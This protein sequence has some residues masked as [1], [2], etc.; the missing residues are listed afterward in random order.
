MKF[1]LNRSG[2]KE[3][4]K[5]A[6]MQSVLREYTSTVERN[7]GSGYSS[8][9]KVGRNRASGR[10]YAYTSEARRENSENNTLL[11]SLHD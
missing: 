2:V 8:N 1:V 3:L 11:R 4:L 9:V 10:V 7:A 6:E 5:S